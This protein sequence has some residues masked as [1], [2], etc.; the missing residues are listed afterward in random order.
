[1]TDPKITK[2]EKAGPE[3]NIVQITDWT[4]ISEC[5]VC[6]STELEQFC[7]NI[8][9][10]RPTTRWSICNICKHVFVNPRPS[11]AWTEAFYI[12]GY[13]AMTHRLKKEDS[14]AIPRSSAEEELS[15]SMH[16]LNNII[17]WRGEG[18]ILNHLD[19]GSSTGALLASTM[20]RF[21]AQTLVGVEPGRAWREF[22]IESYKKFREKLS[23]P[24]ELKPKDS[25]EPT[26][27]IYPTID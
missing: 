23:P 5:P 14:K 2:Q 20:E 3:I 27:V 4:N 9:E 18:P 16:V 25:V 15:R 22:S 8:Q 7:A 17:R 21:G 26:F 24:N 19:I 10:I 6:S 12:D 13:R 1:M 11:D